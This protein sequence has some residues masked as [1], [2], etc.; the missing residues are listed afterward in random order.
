M[1]VHRI[2]A[3]QYR[4]IKLTCAAEARQP[5]QRI[6]VEVGERYNVERGDHFN[7][8]T[9]ILRISDEPNFDDTDLH[10][11]LAW[12][13]FKKYGLELTDDGR[14]LIDTYVYIY[15]GPRS[16]EDRELETNVQFYFD[17]VKGKVKIVA[18]DATSK[19]K[20]ILTEPV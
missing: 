7:Y 8:S 6:D 10:D 18:W 20:Q 12:P 16:F 5:R 11:I 13:S 15:H 17:T 3:D 14:A 9:N 2:T 19:S 4:F 1:N